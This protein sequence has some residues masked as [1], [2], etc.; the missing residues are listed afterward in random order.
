MNTIGLDEVRQKIHRLPSIPTV[1]IDLLNSMNQD[2]VQIDTL[3]KKIG[4]DQAL[5]ARTLRLANSSFYGLARQVTTIQSTIAIL[6]FKTVRSLATSAFLMRSFA[7][8]PKSNFRVTHFWRHA[9]AAAVCAREIA[10]RLNVNPDHAYTAGLIHDIGRL[11]LVTQFQPNYEAAMA[12]RAKHDCSLFEA[13][14]EV[15]GIDHAAVGHALSQH[16]RF[17]EAMQQAVACHHVSNSLELQPLSLVVM[18]ANAVAHG[19]DLSLDDDDL[20]PAVAS[21]LW[22]KLGL[23]EATWIEVLGNAER[24][25]EGESLVL[26]L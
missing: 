5:T 17:P 7:A 26:E 9:I 16:W 24:G 15:L 21:G 22:Q 18:A 13:E 12:Y 14:L 10:S 4:Q 2:D 1:V 11:V 6:G 3:A 25:F 8:S 19:L 20:V 23:D